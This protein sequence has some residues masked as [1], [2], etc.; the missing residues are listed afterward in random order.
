[1]KSYK[2][3]Y[4]KKK[5]KSPLPYILGALLFVFTFAFFFYLFVFSP[6]F[7]LRGIEIEE[8]NEEV[9]T[10][11]KGYVEK[12]L[13]FKKSKSVFILNLSELEKEILKRFPGIREASAKLT[14]SLSLSLD[15]K[16]KEPFLSFCQSSLCFFVDENGVIF[17][18]IENPGKRIAF[19]DS[20]K[21]TALGEKV[22]EEDLSQ[23]I[24]K[25]I[26]EFETKE[27]VIE[28]SR[29]VVITLKEGWSAYFNPK[30]NI[31]EQIENMKIV[32]EEKISEEER[33][34]LEY[35][36]LRFKDRVYYK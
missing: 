29:K 7:F 35:M 25:L 34:E 6:L 27:V 3:K 26:K 4:R 17:E 11:V 12:D 30:E 33:R 14:P 24:H 8:G 19:E 15:I 36:D 21:K 2:K 13:P 5:K 18:L 20:L 22:I 1:M 28:S 10:F 32:L 23:F 31:D 9:E 16:K